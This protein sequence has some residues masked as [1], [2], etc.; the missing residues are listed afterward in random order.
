MTDLSPEDTTGS[1]NSERGVI[2]VIDDERAF[3]EVV[4]EILE[5]IGYT[6]HAA[7][8]AEQGLKLLPEVM[9][10]VILTDVMMPNMDGLSFVR[11][12]R[13]QTQWAETAIVVISAKVTPDDRLNALESG[14][15]EFHAKPFSSYDLEA[16]MKEILQP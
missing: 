12:L 16:L 15:D 7:L 11:F 14:A 13:Q 5:A 10:D 8:N 4:C 6:A 3:C 1:S 9:P 2:L